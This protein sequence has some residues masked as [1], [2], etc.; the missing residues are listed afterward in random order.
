MEGY[1]LSRPKQKRKS[2]IGEGGESAVGPKVLLAG[3]IDEFF[4]RSL[5]VAGVLAKLRDFRQVRK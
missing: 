1:Q 3:L 4:G 2:R 5:F